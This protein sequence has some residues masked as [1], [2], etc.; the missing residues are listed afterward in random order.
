MAQ[1]KLK[2]VDTGQ[3]SNKMLC[4]CDL[5]F[6]FNARDFRLK[7]ATNHNPWLRGYCH[8]YTE[9]QLSKIFIQKRF[10]RVFCRV[11]TKATL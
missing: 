6:N 8:R 7:T 10:T 1:T 3:N 9:L 11:N 4:V 5:T 2:I